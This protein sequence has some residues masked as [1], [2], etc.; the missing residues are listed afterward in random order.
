MDVNILWNALDKVLSIAKDLT[1]FGAKLGANVTAKVAKF[2]PQKAARVA[3]KGFGDLPKE[4]KIKLCA[5]AVCGIA[6]FCTI[7]SLGKKK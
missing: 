6:C 1:M 3:K 5:A 4:D 7:L 2:I